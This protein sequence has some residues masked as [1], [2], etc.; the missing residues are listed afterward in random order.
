[1]RWPTAASARSM[2]RALWRGDDGV[3][4]LEFGLFAPI[5]FFGLLATIDV[6]FALYERMTIDSVLRAGAKS[7]M[8]DAGVTAVQQVLESTAAQYPSS[9]GLSISSPERY[10][11]C[12]DNPDVAVTSTTL[13]SGNPPYIYYRLGANKLYDGLF[14]PLQVGSLR[15]GE[16]TLRSIAQV[17]VR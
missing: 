7:A 14:V 10:F 13:C 11:A 4:A 8:A 9:E 6:G 3:S 17:Q 16:L 15:L 5:L 12:P 1:M 2:L